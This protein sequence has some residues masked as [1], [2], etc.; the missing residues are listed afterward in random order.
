MGRA[1][2]YLNEIWRRVYA[3]ARSK[4]KLVPRLVL[5]VG[6]PQIERHRRMDP[7]AFMHTGGRH[8]AGQVHASPDA[9]MLPIQ[10]IAGLF[11]HEIGHPLAMRVMRRSEQEDADRSILEHVGVK[12]RYGG[13]LLLEYLSPSDMR[14]VFGSG[15]AAN[16]RV[17]T[18]KDVNKRLAQY[19]IELVKGQGYWYFWPFMKEDDHPIMRAS[20]TSVMVYRFSDKTPD[21]WVRD[22]I[23]LIK[24]GLARTDQSWEQ[25]VAKRG[26][27]PFA[28]RRR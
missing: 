11:L 1:E 26:A 28:N 16:G 25:W 18:M 17:P 3:F 5:K 24:E 22:A 15:V 9:A 4:S 8:A 6:C 19:G 14:R 12:I 23:D 13:P 21:E 2:K 10:F 27:A 20:S 7:R